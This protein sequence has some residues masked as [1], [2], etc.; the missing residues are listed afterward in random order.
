MYETNDQ[1][2]SVAQELDPFSSSGSVLG[3]DELV[4]KI[5]QTNPEVNPTMLAGMSGSN[6]KIDESPLRRTNCQP[7]PHHLFEIDGET[8]IVTPQDKEKPKNIK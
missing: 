4:S 6:N 5:T 7:I 3:N 1:I 8:F 2:V